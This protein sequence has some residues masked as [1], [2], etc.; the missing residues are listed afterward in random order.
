MIIFNQ[1]EVSFV[2][3]FMGVNQVNCLI[4]DD[5]YSSRLPVVQKRIAQAG[6]RLAA[7]LN[8]ILDRC[9]GEKFSKIAVV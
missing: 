3:S 8:R 4:T 6:V 1:F 9:V 2:V 5:Y 7:V